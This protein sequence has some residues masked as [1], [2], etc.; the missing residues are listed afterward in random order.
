MYEHSYESVGEVGPQKPFV[1]ICGQSNL[2]GKTANSLSEQVGG[3]HYRRLPIQPIEFIQKNSIPF[4]E[5]NVIKYLCRW[6]E[7]NGVADLE[8]AR[9]YIDMLIEMEA[10]E[11]S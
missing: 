4:I 6:R 11:C 2:P 5:G 7:K 9:H 3:D 1:H 8:K 10:P